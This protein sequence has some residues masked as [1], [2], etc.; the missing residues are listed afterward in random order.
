[1]LNVAG[2]TLDVLQGGEHPQDALSL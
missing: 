2:L 1:V